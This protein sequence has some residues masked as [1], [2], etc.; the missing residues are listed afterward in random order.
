M[1][2]ELDGV[3]R[4]RALLQSEAMALEQRESHLQHMQ[5][6]IVA[7]S[8]ALCSVD[9]IVAGVGY[10]DLVVVALFVDGADCV[11]GFVFATVVFRMVWHF[12]SARIARQLQVWG[13][14]L[15]KP[16]Q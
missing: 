6:I 12:L 1:S 9:S 11:D 8:Q 2:R 3:S 5:S 4:G 7:Q 16:G 14:W 13:L 10:D 15:N